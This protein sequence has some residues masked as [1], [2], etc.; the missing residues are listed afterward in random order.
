[1]G[2]HATLPSTIYTGQHQETVVLTFQWLT[3]GQL[4]GLSLS[5]ASRCIGKYAMSTNDAAIQ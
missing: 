2:S 1:M 4:K 5:V 3:N